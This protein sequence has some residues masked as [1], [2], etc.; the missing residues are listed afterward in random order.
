[1]LSMRSP[2]YDPLSYNNGAVWPFV[3]GFAILALYQ[4]DRPEAA[5]QYLD[6]LAQLPSLESRGFTAEL[7]SGD[8]LRTVDAAVPHQLFATSGFVS[9]LL[10][11]LVGFDGGS[12]VPSAQAV[13]TAPAAPADEPLVLRPSLPAGWRELTVRGLRWRQHKVNVHLSL[14][15]DSV[16][17]DVEATPGPLPIVVDLRL[18]PGA[19]P[20]SVRVG[21]RVTGRIAW[22][23]AIRRPGIS[24]IP[25]RRPLVAGDAS[26]RLRVVEVR[27]DGEQVIAR[28]AGQAGKDYFVDVEPAQAMSAV[29]ADGVTMQPEPASAAGRSRFRLTFPSGDAGWREAQLTFVRTGKTK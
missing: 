28:M 6:A 13:M 15:P 22:E 24:L 20:A 2:M 29:R 26:S 7:Y 11:G 3:T 10:R 21:G 4:Q 23:Q 9:G 19:D 8:R 5:W 17:I 16:R 27:E 12:V 14:Q 1:M 25:E 18:P